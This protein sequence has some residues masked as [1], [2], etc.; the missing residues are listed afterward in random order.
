MAT[1]QEAIGEVLK[2]QQ[3]GQFQQAEQICEKILLVE[4]EHHETWH[5]RGVLAHLQNRDYDGVAFIERAVKLCPGSSN[6]HYNL[7]VIL[8]R[9]AESQSE[10]DAQKSAGTITQAEAHY[11]IAI[12]LDGENRSAVSNLAHLFQRQGRFTD[13][14]NCF[15]RLVDA[16]PE[17]ASLRMQLGRSY[18]VQGGI[19]E[20]LFHLRKAVELGQ[21]DP[22]IDGELLFALQY[23]P[24]ISAVK[25]ASM[26][27]T[28]GENYSPISAGAA[29]AKLISDNTVETRQQPIRI[30][31]VSPDLGNHPVGIFLAPLFERIDRAR[32]TV[33]CF[34]DRSDVDHYCQRLRD[35]ASIWHDTKPLSDEQLG[36]LIRAE[37]IDVLVDLAG[38]TDNNRLTL[39]AQRI[40]SVQISWAGYV[41]TTG[42]NSIDW[43]LCDGFHV[44]RDLEKLLTEKPLR[45]PNG[46][47]GFAPPD[48]A[49]AVGPLPALEKQHV[50]F[51]C[52][53]NIT[54]LNSAVV[55]V[56]AKI[57]HGVE[58][59]KILFKYKGFDDLGAQ[60]RIVGWFADC[61]IE[62]K[63]LEFQGQTTHVHH[64]AELNRVD[65]AL[66]PF[67]YS[68]GLTTCEMIWM[69]VP[70]VTV[71][72]ERFASRH[73]FSHL[74][75]A[76]LTDTI[77]DSLDEYVRIAISL[78][79][80]LDE[81]AKTRATM[82]DRI[83][84]S[85][86]CNLH[87]FSLDFMT[88]IE[89]TI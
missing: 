46:Y 10:T 27:K 52:F 2:L 42:L 53:N 31:F 41:G 18:K 61:G 58:E 17:S 37:A 35:S 71:P 69:G 67:P 38:H 45:M 34:S 5:V 88:A 57:L 43:L 3:A 54:K 20:S 23:D 66:D 48:Y 30:G 87:Q 62:S 59:S 33:V 84:N 63:R 12:E 79:T 13:G 49:P 86:L 56:W 7:A 68:G 51:G 15:T 32:F 16:H 73:S 44:P 8:Q 1:V 25:L 47:I 6:Y 50:T 39:F 22:R 80:D 29:P 75:N 55:E 24:T 72:S 26:H 40:A 14:V 64:L 65:I 11:S 4:F 70:V 9:I 74:S 76:G 81:L 36:E 78:A 19:E 21:G 77:A 83:A 28:W 82:R 85:A 89:S 60:S